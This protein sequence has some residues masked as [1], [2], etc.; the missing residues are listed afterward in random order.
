MK[1]KQ[2][3]VMKESMVM[4]V[5]P[6]KSQDVLVLM[7]WRAGGKHSAAQKMKK[8]VKKELAVKISVEEEIVKKAVEEE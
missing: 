3:G 5:A 1:L 2:M 8:A 6:L 7:M 4:V